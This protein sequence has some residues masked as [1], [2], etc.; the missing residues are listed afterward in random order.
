[1]Y[2]ARLG[3]SCSMWDLVAQPGTKP[4]APVLGVQ[5]LRHWITKEVL[6]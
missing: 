2:V 4:R 5:S 1:M 6:A 3:P